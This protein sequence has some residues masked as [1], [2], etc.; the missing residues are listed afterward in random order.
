[1]KISTVLIAL[2]LIACLAVMAF[3]DGEGYQWKKGPVDPGDEWI[4]P[5]CTRISGTPA[6]TYTTDDGVTMATT[7]LL[8]G[9]VYTY[10]LVALD[11][12]NVLLASSMT[13]QG[14]S[15]LRS[16]DAGCSWKEVTLLGVNELLL[17]KAAPGGKAYGY[18]RGRD[19]FYRIEGQAVYTLTAPNKVYGLAVDPEDAMH[20]R[21]GSMDCQIYESFDGGASFALLGEPANTGN[22]IFY[23]FAFDPQNWDNALCASIGAWRSTDA[24]QTW[25]TVEPFDKIDIDIVFEFLYSP[26][27]PQRVW[28]RANLETMGAGYRDILVSG[29]GGATFQTAVR[30]LDVALD[31]NGIERNVILTNQPPMAVHPVDDAVYF[32]YGSYIYDYGT[33]L[34]KYNLRDDELTAAHTDAL[35]GIDAMAFNPIDPSVMYLGLEEEGTGKLQAPT[36]TVSQTELRVNAAPN[37]FNPATRLSFYLPQAG[38]VKLEVFNITGQKISTVVDA[39][40]VAGEHTVM[41]NGSECASGIYLYRLEAGQQSLTKKMVLLK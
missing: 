6:V 37:P 7:S 20:I 2:A 8:R 32:V 30:Q 28:A 41:W 38:H 14:T 19:T 24:G 31:Q 5:T 25:S 4:V 18:S 3:A 17:L 40:M 13:S 27:N 36:T 34:F 21:F 15:I 23:D 39:D 33:D 16:D 26:S 10:G 29:D 9:I 12:A 35:D 1:M 22:G 11:E